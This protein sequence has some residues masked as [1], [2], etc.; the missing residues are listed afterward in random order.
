MLEDSEVET[1]QHLY[2]AF[3]LVI[4]QVTHSMRLLYSCCVDIQPY[5][6]GS[7]SIYSLI[8]AVF[9]YFFLAGIS[10]NAIPSSLFEC[11]HKNKSPSLICRV[12]HFERKSILDSVFSSFC[13]DCSFPAPAKCIVQRLNLEIITVCLSVCLSIT[14]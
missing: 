3:P 12:K 1:Y 4:S 14:G 13:A 9:N 10:Q 8:D 6:C 11:L 5:C 7:Y 2:G